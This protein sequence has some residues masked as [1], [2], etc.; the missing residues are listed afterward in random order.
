MV[1]R[2]KRWHTVHRVN[3]RSTL[4]LRSTQCTVHRTPEPLGHCTA[5]HRSLLGRIKVPPTCG[6]WCHRW[7]GCCV[8]WCM[9]V[10]GV[11][12]YGVVVYGVVVYGVVG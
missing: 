4:L 1:G 7:P 12:V 2:R 9:V 11:V 6:H 3:L 10:C 8:V 5:V